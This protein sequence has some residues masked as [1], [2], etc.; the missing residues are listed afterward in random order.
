MPDKD[1]ALTEPSEKPAYLEFSLDDDAD[2]FE[3][4]KLTEEIQ[5]RA[6]TGQ[7]VKYFSMHEYPKEGK[8]AAVLACI[9]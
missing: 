9:T 7:Y 3:S 8:L 4:L 2:L 5:P 6:A 1:D